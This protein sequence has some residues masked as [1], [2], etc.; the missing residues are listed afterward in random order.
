MKG[1]MKS[2]LYETKLILAIWCATTHV[3]DS[4]FGEQKKYVL[5][6]AVEYLKD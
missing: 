3:V 5:K 1:I 4:V 6:Y 2:R